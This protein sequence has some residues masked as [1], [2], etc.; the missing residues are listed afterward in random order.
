MGLLKILAKKK[1]NSEERRILRYL[2]TSE[3]LFEGKR[4]LHHFERVF[5]RAK[6]FVRNYQGNYKQ[7]FQGKIEKIG[8]RHK[9]DFGYLRHRGE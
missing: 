7:F 6:S 5:G 3:R 9:M 2:E 4:D 8:S 1:Y